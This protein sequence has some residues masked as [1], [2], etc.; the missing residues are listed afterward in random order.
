[1]T[2]KRREF[3]LG[4][5]FPQE[6]ETAQAEHFEPKSNLCAKTSLDLGD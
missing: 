1:M 3:T 6:F 2:V 5:P 4:R